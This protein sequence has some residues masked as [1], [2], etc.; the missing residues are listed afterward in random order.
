MCGRQLSGRVVKTWF[1][2]DA[3]EKQCFVARFVVN[4]QR[5]YPRSAT[6]QALR[7]L[8]ARG[9]P[10]GDSPSLFAV[11]YNDIGRSGCR[12]FADPSFQRLL[13]PKK[14]Q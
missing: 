4:Y 7:S 11:F 9:D 5:H 13:V 1:E 6:N 12:R 3:R 8:S 10:H 14:T 2:L